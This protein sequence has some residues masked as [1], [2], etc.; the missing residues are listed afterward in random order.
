ML[1]VET[2]FMLKN[3]SFTGVGEGFAEEQELIIDS[4]EPVLP[5]VLTWTDDE[6]MANAL[7]E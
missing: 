7:L 5:V 6:V 4:I 3:D 2:T 1:N